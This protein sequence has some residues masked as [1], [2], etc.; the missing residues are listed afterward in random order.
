LL[1][2]GALSPNDCGGGKSGLYYI[3]GWDIK[4]LSVINYPAASSGVLPKK[5]LADGPHAAYDR[6]SLVV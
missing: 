3:F 1:M 4:D 6:C 5:G 2:E